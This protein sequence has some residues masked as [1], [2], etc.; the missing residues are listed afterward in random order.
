MT[1]DGSCTTGFVSGAIAACVAATVS[2][3]AEVSVPPAHRRSPE[4]ALTSSSRPQVIKTRMQLSG[5]LGSKG[6]AAVYSG[7][8]DCASK[9]WRME[10]VRGIQRGLTAAVSSSSLGVSRPGF[11]ADHCPVLSISLFTRLL[12]R[13]PPACLLHEQSA[14]PSVSRRPPSQ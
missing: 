12:V 14:D 13:L 11:E 1:D 10:G 2:N 4:K 3:P 7:P 8:L 6:K 9:T 5:E